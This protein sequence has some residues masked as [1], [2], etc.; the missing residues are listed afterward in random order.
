MTEASR[1]T[2]ARKKAEVK[3]E[4]EREREKRERGGKKRKETGVPSYETSVQGH[5]RERV[6][7]ECCIQ[8]HP[9]SQRRKREG[10]KGRKGIKVP[11]GS[12]E[13]ALT[14][15]VTLRH[16]KMACD[17]GPLRSPNGLSEDCLLGLQ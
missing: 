14:A 4:R 3:R 2:Q 5:T 12:S 10:G 7:H 8:E 9:K 16:A 1:D 13:S 11:T 15:L 17:L 6:G